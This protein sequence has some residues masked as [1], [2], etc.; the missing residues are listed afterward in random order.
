MPSGNQAGISAPEPIDDAFPVKPKMAEAH[1][2]HGS[3]LGRAVRATV[4]SLR[5]SRLAEGFFHSAGGKGR[6]EIAVAAGHVARAFLETGCRMLAGIRA[7]G[8]V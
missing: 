7:V 2:F 6:D 4:P 5:K 1:R 3:A 8:C